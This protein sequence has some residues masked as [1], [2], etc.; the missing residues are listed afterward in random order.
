MIKQTST[1]AKQIFFWNMM[2][3]LCNAASTV[4]LTMVVTRL[5]GAGEEADIFGLA[6]GVAQVMMTIGSFEVRP[7]QSTDLNEKY[8]FSNYLMFRIASSILMMVATAVVILASGY[9]GNKALV[10]FLLSIYRMLDAVSDLF[11]GLF[12]QHERLDL[13]GKSLAIRV[14][15][16][17]AVFTICLAVTRNLTISLIG[18]IIIS[19]LWIWLYDVTKVKWFTTISWS[20]SFCA[21]KRLFLDCL[22]LFAGAFMLNYILNSPKYSVD[23]F[24]GQL[25]K[26]W[27]VIF[28]P[29]AVINLFS[30]FIFRPMLTTLAAS[31]NLKQWKSFLS[32]IKKVLIS[33]F[34]I[35]GLVLVAGYF[36]GIP[37][38]SWFYNLDLSAYRTELMVVLLGGGLSAVTTVLYYLV[39]VMRKQY[40]ILVGYAVPFLLS[41]FL[42][43]LFVRNW[44]LMGAALAYLA[45]MAIQCAVFFMIFYWFYRRERRTDDRLRQAAEQMES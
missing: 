7:F 4:V 3:S 39:T 8:T 43:P 20:F 26:Y 14:V 12:Q 44:D 38:L 25:Q 33:L 42:V 9:E 24:C 6:L 37:V 34:F 10:V 41:F 45:I 15:L 35:T 13:S 40:C 23:T 22:P 18:M 5:T 16:C 27:T 19:I 17:T 28:M 36:L 30:I 31:W 29:A 32:I 1:G 11:Q 21:L 2:G